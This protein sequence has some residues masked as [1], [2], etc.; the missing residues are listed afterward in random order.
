MNS[1]SIRWCPQKNFVV[2]EFN[3]YLKPSLDAGHLTNDGPLQIVLQSKARKFF[4]CSNEVLLAANGTA[5]LHALVA[6]ISLETGRPLKWATQAFTF[7]SSIQGP[8]QDSIV[9]DN[10][11]IYLGPSI[12]GLEANKNHFDGVI[13]TN[14][15]GFQTCIEVYEKWCKDNNK[16]L[17]FDNAATP[18]G[19]LDDGRNIHDI[20]NG[21]IVSF[22]ETKPVGRGEGGAVIMSSK[23]K[24]FVHQAMNFGFDVSQAIRVPN[25]SSSNWRMSD[26]AAAAI[27]A[28]LDFIERK[29]WAER[30]HH[31]TALVNERLQD[32]GIKFGM[33]GATKLPVFGNTIFIQL[34]KN[35]D[36]DSIQKSLLR[37]GIEAKRYYR[38]LAHQNECPIAWEWYEKSICLPH[39]VD[40]SDE[41]VEKILLVL[42]ENI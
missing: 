38:P 27:C 14:C 28:H 10:D 21:S 35:Q 23:L 36:A 13:V 5:A 39:H 20:G 31:L 29:N 2:E 19:S 1:L 37:S 7:P 34:S 18:L 26:I 41:D 25:R 4:G 30:L 32:I 8:L 17:V 24:K 22:H 12:A 11:P 42:K 9:V 40:I 16:F 33:F 6:G 15:F 3:Q